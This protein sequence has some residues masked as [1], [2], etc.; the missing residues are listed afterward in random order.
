MQTRYL[1]MRPGSVL[2]EDGT[3]FP[4]PLTL[5][6]NNFKAT[7]TPQAVEL[8]ESEICYFWKI[9]YSIYGTPEFDDMILTLN[10]VPHRNQLE[11]EDIIYIPKKDDILT[12][13]SV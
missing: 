5:N 2:D 8:T 11:P 9:P 4:D 3:A 7:E 13:F 10:G 6:I 1:F 12:S